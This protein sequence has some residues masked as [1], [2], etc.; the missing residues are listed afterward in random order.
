MIDEKKAQQATPA[1]DLETQIMSH[2]V[3]KSEREW[4]AQREI[5]RLRRQLTT[6]Q[7]EKQR[8]EGEL[9]RLEK[10]RTMT[11]AWLSKHGQHASYCE[12]APRQ[13]CSCGYEELHDALNTKHPTQEP[14]NGLEKAVSK[15]KL[16]E[17]IKYYR[18]PVYSSFE[19]V[20]HYEINCD[21]LLDEINS[22]RLD[23]E[24]G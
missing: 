19:H 4:W 12:N 7:A 24:E 15:K 10:L 3:P 11:F 2:C 9:G 6:L 17:F 8:L 1:A 16:E 14:T 13:P 21:L 20:S 22:G 18:E 5:D 23:V